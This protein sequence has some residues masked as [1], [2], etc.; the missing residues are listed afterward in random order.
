MKCLNPSCSKEATTRGN[1][2]ICYNSLRR[3]VALGETTWEALEQA[4][5]VLKSTKKRNAGAWEGIKL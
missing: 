3:D 4:G 5:R 2:P 1:C